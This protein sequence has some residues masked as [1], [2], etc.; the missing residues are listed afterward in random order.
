VSRPAG[1]FVLWVE[2]PASLASRAIFDDALDHNICFV[3]GDVFS[4][5]GRYGHCLRVSCGHNWHPRIENGLK[6]LGRIAS[7]ASARHQMS[8][9]GGGVEA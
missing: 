7:T 5:S 3:P 1:G 9:V 4:A 2:L 6:T 8:A